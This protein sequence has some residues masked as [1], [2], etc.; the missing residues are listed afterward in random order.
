MARRRRLA[1]LAALTALAAAAAIGAFARPAPPNAYVV[2]ALASDRA[3]AARIRDTSLVNP[4]GLAASPT[5]PWWTANEAQDSSTLYADNGAKQLLTVTVE[6]GPTGVAYNGGRG[7][8]VRA[9]GVAYPA[10]FV[11]ASEDGM[12]RGWSPSVPTG[13]STASEVAI[14]RS[15]E[16]AVFRSLAIATLRDGSSRLYATDFHNGRV[17]V[18]DEQWRPV[19]RAGAFED[20]A[21]PAWYAPYGIYAH[22][23]RVFVTF[24]S[25]APVNGNDA[26]TG[27]YVDE[28]DV[29]GRLVARVARMGRL[30][31]P[32]GLALAPSG[33]G[34]F[35]GDL[36]VANFGDGHVNAFRRDGG[37]WSYDGTLRRPDGRPIAINGL[38]GI[39]FGNGRFAGRTDTLYFTAGPHRWRGATETAVH[40]L[41]GS[42]VAVH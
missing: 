25:P 23:D 11:Y 6:G 30:R 7:F 31:A 19:V 36:L 8:V 21:I 39:A 4:F 35:G 26:P 16:G 28:F 3:G 22:G 12:I 32:W 29:D 27:G 42:I 41:F 14:D 2:R 13:W 18:F 20:A 34:R 37:S 15:G 1:V 38:W 24:A 9:R 10:R 17:N 33:F 40:G 5:G